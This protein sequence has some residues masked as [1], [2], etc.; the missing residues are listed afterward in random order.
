MVV[1]TRLRAI[2]LPI[3]LYIV[4]GGVTSYFV[5]NAVNG[6]RGLRAK[7]A[8]RAEMAKLD[9]ELADL[10]AERKQLEQ[11]VAMMGPDSVDRDLLEEEA[12]SVLGLARPSDLVVF[13]PPQ[14]PSN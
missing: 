4:S 8:Y 3:A 1:R 13:L 6:G 9:G 2:L 14:P 11:R 7:D 10:T 12:R 5:W